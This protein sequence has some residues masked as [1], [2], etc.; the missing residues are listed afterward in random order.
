MRKIKKV[1][2]DESENTFY[3]LDK[4]ASATECTGIAPAAPETESE[5]EEV[6]E[7]YAI[8]TP[9]AKKGDENAE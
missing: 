9:R 1:A 5:A 6:G 3:D 8:H 4:V 7:L 2:F